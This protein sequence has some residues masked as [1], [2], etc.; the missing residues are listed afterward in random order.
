MVEFFKRNVKIYKTEQDEKNLVRK[1]VGYVKELL[2][3]RVSLSLLR[4]KNV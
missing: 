2:F 4:I 1:Y 3:L